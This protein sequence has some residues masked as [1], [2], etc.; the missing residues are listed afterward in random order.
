MRKI[1]L[2]IF[3]LSM[4]AAWMVGCG[5]SSKHIVPPP[6][7]T[8]SFAFMQEVGSG[9]YIFSPMIGTFS[10][11]GG[12]TTFSAAAALS[13]SAQ[14]PIEVTF[15][16]IYLSSDATLATL[17]LFGG[18][19]GTSGQWDIWVAEA[20]GSHNPTQVTNDTNDNEMPQ[21][22]PDNTRVAFNSNRVVDESGDLSYV[23]V[24]RKI[25]GTGEQVLALPPGANW[26]YAP[27]YSPDGSKIAVEAYGYD[28]TNDAYYDGIWIMNA[29]DGSSP[30]MLTNPLANCNCYDET[31]AYTPDGTKIVF[32]REA[33][34]D[35]STDTE[36]IYI[37]NADGTGATQLTKN[38]AVN[39]DPLV[40]NV[41]GVSQILFSS[42]QSNPTDVTGGSFDLYSMNM[43]GTGVTRLT[44]NSQYD[45]F[46][47]E[48][49]Q[50]GD[51]AAQ[52]AMRHARGPRHSRFM[53]PRVAG[54]KWRR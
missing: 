48:W 15:Y 29:A 37:M 10:T 33:T 18:L 6:A 44:T 39:F 19:D 22:S 3:L 40:I 26:T 43:D 16:S 53:E 28:S 30:T 47:G 11:S 36:D 49:Y 4:T 35:S 25:D 12:N 42:N 41:N 32:S 2:F 7:K 14:Q 31:P 17:D 20:T 50:W 46:C 34:G 45:A 5:S 21:L 54:L 52:V 13:G 24:T 8:S 1:L 23:V 9:S 27:T 51:A 38:G